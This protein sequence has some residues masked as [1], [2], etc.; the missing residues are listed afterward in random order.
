LFRGECR[1]AESDATAG[2]GTGLSSVE[3]GL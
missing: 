1:V 2:V 3:A